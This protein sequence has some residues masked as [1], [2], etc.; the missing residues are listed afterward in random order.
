MLLI[1]SS[2]FKRSPSCQLFFCASERREERLYFSSF[3]PS[4]SLSRS[5]KSSF[6]FKT[7]CHFFMRYQ[8]FIF[9]IIFQKTSKPKTHTKYTDAMIAAYNV[10]S[11]MSTS[12]MRTSSEFPHI[13]QNL[14]VPENI[15]SY[16]QNN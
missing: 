3:I 10:Y 1:P 15:F 16:P 8:L 2:I 4:E 5:P 12:N 7:V 6:I 13:L 14:L 11:H 9:V